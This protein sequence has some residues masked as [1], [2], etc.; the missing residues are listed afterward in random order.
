MWPN[1]QETMDLVTFTGEIFNGKHRFLCSVLFA[2]ENKY[3][4]VYLD[5]CLFKIIDKQMVNYLDDHLLW[6]W[7]KLILYVIYYN[8]IIFP[9]EIDF[10]KSKLILLITK[11][12]SL[13]LLVLNLRFKFQES[14]CNSSLY[15]LMMSPNVSNIAVIPVKGVVY[16]CII[17]EVSEPDEIN[18]LEH[19]MLDNC[20]FI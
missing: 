5:K 16:N 14:V 1:P 3:L 7:W 6:L 9:E 10:S 13:L 4:P 12:V 8:K 15:L 2:Y 18:L 11:N 17:Y 19:S 20:G